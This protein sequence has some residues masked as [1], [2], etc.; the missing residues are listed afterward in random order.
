M[1]RLRRLLEWKEFQ[2][3][4]AWAVRLAAERRAEE[5]ARELEVL[6]KVAETSKL[7]VILG[8]KGLADSVLKLV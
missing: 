6:E 8:E 7:N 3:K 4:R 5:L 2:E 1:F